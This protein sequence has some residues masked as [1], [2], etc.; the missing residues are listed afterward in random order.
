M[1]VLFIAQFISTQSFKVSKKNI[2]G[3]NKNVFRPVAFKKKNHQTLRNG[4]S[5]ISKTY[6]S[7][8]ESKKHN[9]K[10][11]LVNITDAVL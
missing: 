6:L 9:N 4:I 8:R 2:T 11:N 10:S 7:V 5:I 1:F 3:E